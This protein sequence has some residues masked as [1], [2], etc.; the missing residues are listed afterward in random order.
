MINW[1]K[2]TNQ[3]CVATQI[4]FTLSQTSQLGGG[5]SNQA[6]ELI[7]YTDT[8]NKRSELQYFVKLNDATKENML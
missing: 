8:G 3:I 5:D 6:W 2:I 7:G 1:G 4:H